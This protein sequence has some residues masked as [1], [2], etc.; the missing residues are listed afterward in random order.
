M[1]SKS[2]RIIS[3]I[4]LLILIFILSSCNK[5][6]L[7]T[8]G[9][10]HVIVIDE[11]IPATC[12]EPGLS[13]G[14]HCSVCN[15][16]LVKQNVIPA[17]H[18]IV[19]DK[20]VKATCTET[21]LTEG[22][23]CSVCNAI[24]IE[25]NIIPANGHSYEY[26][27]NLENHFGYCSICGEVNTENHNIDPITNT[28]LDC[29]FEIVTPPPFESGYITSE[30]TVIET[31][32][33]IC[34]I[35]A[36]IYVIDN[37]EY[38][39]ETLYDSLQIVS[40][41]SFNI[42]KYGKI[43]IEVKKAEPVDG[44][45]SEG[46]NAYSLGDGIVIGAGD[47]FISSGYAIAHELSHVLQSHNSRWYYCKTLVEGFAEYTTYKVIGYM[48]EN[49]P[50]VAFMLGSKDYCIYNMSINTEGYEKL[51]DQPLYYWYE[52]GFPYAG[53]KDYTIGFRL[54]RYLDEVYGEY[55]SWITNYQEVNPYAG[56]SDR[57][58]INE[59]I[60]ILP[61]T[62]GDDVQDNFYPWLKQNEAF[63]EENYFAVTDRTKLSYTNIY[64][65]YWRWLDTQSFVGLK[66][67]DIYLNIDELERYIIDYKKD[68]LGDFR[69]RVKTIEP[70]IIK[71]YDSN[72]YLMA[73]KTSDKTINTYSLKGVGFI[74]FVGEGTIIQFNILGFASIE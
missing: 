4:V 55:S 39:I 37:L 3:A 46:H 16:I 30:Y 40:G 61:M 12:T 31:E 65:M 21:G 9:H 26:E 67:K 36:D 48:E 47:L 24:L 70:P 15:A 57:L 58:D 18:N 11:S 8:E 56:Y 17:Q 69:F 23:H 20:A 59:A 44:Y 13:E 62:Y 2:T 29:D 52:N 38:R 27:F 71:F 74:Q 34:K 53:N 63:F 35:D 49:Y 32:H 1:K 19:V 54:M 60:K 22:S 42:D 73:I 33:F 45:A 28:C 51:Y 7:E 6:P 41:L 50:D 10:S 14:S 5:I 25:Q 72:G 43:F 64:P 66:Y 68:K